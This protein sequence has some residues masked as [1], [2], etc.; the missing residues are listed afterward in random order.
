MPPLFRLRSLWLPTWQG[1]CVI[2]VVTVA[3]FVWWWFNGESFL[4]I[5]ER[6]PADILIVEGW[7]GIDGVRAAKQE[8]ERGNYRWVVAAGSMTSNRWGE[9]RWNYATVAARTLVNLGVPAD[10]VI[11][12]RA[13]ETPSQRSFAAAIAVRKILESR[14]IDISKANVFTLGVHT[15]RSRLVFAKALGSRTQVGSV[16]WIP[17][18]DAPVPWWKSSERAQDLLKE[19]VAY[20]LELLLNSGRL[21]NQP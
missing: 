14:G 11:E 15:R 19:S 5:T 20:P 13:E 9:E 10:R 17:P 2:L 4:S 6:Q 3:P 12:A 1:C 7:I 18:R 21:S 16:A 8:F